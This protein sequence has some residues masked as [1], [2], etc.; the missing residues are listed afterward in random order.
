MS[1]FTF[2]F[3]NITRRPEKI[4]LPELKNEKVKSKRD[5]DSKMQ[6]AGLL[7]IAQN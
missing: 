4:F 1:A 6:L 2:T 5:I 3:Q 7:F